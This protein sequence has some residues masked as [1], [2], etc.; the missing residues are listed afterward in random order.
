MHPRIL[1]TVLRQWCYNS[2]YRQELRVI[3][4]FL[5]QECKASQWH[6]SNSNAGL[7]HE[8]MTVG[9]LYTVF[10]LQSSWTVSSRGKKEAMSVASV[11]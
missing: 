1:A 4:E 9:S 7:S 8:Y 11:H 10:F 2:T 3:K 5:I 6:K